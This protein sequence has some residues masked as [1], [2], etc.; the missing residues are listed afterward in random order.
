MTDK[1]VPVVCT[2]AVDEPQ[3]KKEMKMEKTNLDFTGN[4]HD[5][6]DSQIGDE[7]REIKRKFYGVAGLKV[8]VLLDDEI[9]C[10]AT[11]KERQT[12]IFF[13]PVL[14][15]EVDEGIAQGFREFRANIEKIIL[16]EGSTGGMKMKPTFA[17]RCM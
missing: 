16:T 3:D 8:E 14:F 10:I 7:L 17:R 5:C 4:V 6:F 13:K 2:H 9:R 12:S 1:V 15:T 11:F